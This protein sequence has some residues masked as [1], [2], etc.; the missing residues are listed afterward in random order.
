[1]RNHFRTILRALSGAVI[2]A[3]RCGLAFA[4]LTGVTWAGGLYISEFGTPSMGVA[5]A[6]T[7]AVASDAS[8]SFH[9]SAG[10]TRLDGKELML[11][12]GLIHSTVKFDAD[13][14]TPVPGGN[15]GDAGGPGP[16]AGAFYVHSLT[17]RLKI[18]ANI[19]SITGAILD[20]ENDWAGRFQSQEV[21]LL[22]VTFNP[23][24]AYRV[25]DWLSVGV[26]PQV[27]YANLDLK[28][29][30]PPPPLPVP[31]GTEEGTVEIDGDDFAFGYNV[32]ALVE[33]GERT[34]LGIAYQSEIEPDFGGDVKIDP[35]GR[36]TGVDTEITLARFVKA[37]LYHEFNDRF[38]VL[39]TVDWEDWSSFKNINLSTS[40]GSQ[41]IPRNWEDTWKFAGGIHFRPTPPLLLQAGLSYDTSPVDS[42]DR[43]ADMPIDR[44]IRYA[45]GTQYQWS[46]TCS[47]GSQF[48]YAD[49]GDA[50]IRSSLLKGEYERNDIFFFAVNANWKL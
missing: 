50:K 41:K 7:N 12:G 27:M 13:S 11:T 1:M 45:L 17:D 15:G 5:G 4:F 32:S 31:G 3:A 29:A 6:G 25:A 38:A 16:L 39:G 33:L 22:T 34:R 43:T 21:T 40:D 30:I 9:N 44:Q 47:I 35:I 37:S 36:E 2:T 23:T 8:T 19:I 46:E 28:A 18:G 26:G 24:I 48:V 14:D 10:M 42:D 20:Y 49:Y